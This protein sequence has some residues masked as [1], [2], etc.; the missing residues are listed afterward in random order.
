M[1][2]LHRWLVRNDEKRYY[3]VLQAKNLATLRK[4]LIASKETVIGREDRLPVAYRG[5]FKLACSKMYAG[6]PA[7]SGWWDGYS[8]P[9]GG[10]K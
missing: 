2:F 1:T 5:E 3:Y 4:R 7:S 9:K 6:P 10:C 8:V